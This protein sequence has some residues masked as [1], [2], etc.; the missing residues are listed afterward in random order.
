MVRYA[1]HSNNYF[2]YVTLKRIVKFEPPGVEI[3]MA[4]YEYRS[5]ASSQTVEI[6]WFNEHF[7]RID[8]I[9]TFCT[10]YELYFEWGSLHGCLWPLYGFFTFST[11]VHNYGGPPP[12]PPSPLPPTTAAS[13]KNPSSLDSSFVLFSSEQIE[14][15]P[16]WELIPLGRAFLPL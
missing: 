14:R 9:G 11:I 10:R 2:D 4:K 16:P 1:A 6:G 15:S 5:I 13:L 8:H 3:S 12:P 7:Q